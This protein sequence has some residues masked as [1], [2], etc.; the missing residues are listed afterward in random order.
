MFLEEQRQ[1]TENISQGDQYYKAYLPNDKTVGAIIM[2][3]S[4][5]K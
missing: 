1:P 3:L 4:G 5:E 2:H